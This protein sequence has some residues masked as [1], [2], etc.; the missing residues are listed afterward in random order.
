LPQPVAADRQAAPSVSVLLAYSDAAESAGLVGSF[1]KAGLAE[2]IAC[3]IARATNGILADLQPSL[4]LLQPPADVDALLAACEQ[5]RSVTDLPVAVLSPLRDTLV[6]TRAFDTG[7]DEYLVLPMDDA[8]LVARTFALARRWS[9]ANHNG[10]LSYQG[11]QLIADEQKVEHNG[12]CVDLT[13]MEFRLLACLVAAQGNVVTHDYLMANVWGAE[14]V[15]SRHYLHL[16]IRYLREKLEDDPKDPRLVVSEWGI[17]Y[18]LQ[19][20]AR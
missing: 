8:E 11:L 10:K 13:P 18:R 9:A 7:I 4:I 19:P 17:G 15:D 12:K 16:Y 14:Y 5:M 1:S 6:I 20:A 3:P 2:I